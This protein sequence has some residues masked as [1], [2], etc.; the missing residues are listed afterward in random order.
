MASPAV[1]A[2]D[3]EGRPLKFET[4]LDDLHLFLQ[5]TAK[6][7][8]SLYDHALGNAAA[9]ATTADNL[10][11]FATVT[12][13]TTHLRTSEARFR[14]A[15]PAEFLATHP[16]PL[17]LTLYHLVTR[18]PDSLRAVRDHFLARCPTELTVD[19]LE[20]ELLA[21]E[22]SIVAV[23]ASRGDPRTPFFEGSGLRPLR[24]GA[25][26]ARAK[27]A[28]E[29]EVT[30]GEAVV[31]A[32]EAVGVVAGQEGLVAA[33]GVVAAA[34]EEVAGV[35]AVV[36]AAVDE[37]AAGA[38]VVEVVAAEVVVVVARVDSRLSL[39]RSFVSGAS[40]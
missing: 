33:V 25:A 19:L 30:A 8:I 3:A 2:F 14:A 40:S 18:L 24:A 39:P 28:R 12:D 23:A 16:P 13:L 27:G 9:P 36:G 7:D 29:V 21:A 37:A 34:A 26:A 5:L 10:S 31:G 38:V 22:T 35:G 1:L 6:E 11:A 4:W 15:M 32:V 20:K 17:W